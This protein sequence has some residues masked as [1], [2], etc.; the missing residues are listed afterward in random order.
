MSAEK[1]IYTQ[2][3][4]EVI[5]FDAEDVIVTS[6]SVVDDDYNDRYDYPC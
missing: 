6:A 1:K 4:V 3:Q 2:P 5:R